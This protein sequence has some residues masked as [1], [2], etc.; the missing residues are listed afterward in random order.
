MSAEFLA[1]LARALDR[2]LESISRSTT[3]TGL[4]VDSFELVEILVRLQEELNVRIF[5]EDLH[6]IET[7]GDLESLF[8]RKK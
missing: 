7:V 6:G 3:L 4:D 2:P 8:A 1:S 5:Q